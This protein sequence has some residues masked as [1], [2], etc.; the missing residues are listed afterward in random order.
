[1]STTPSINQE[2]I[3]KP[4]GLKKRYVYTIGG[5]HLLNDLM[6][7]GIIPVLLPLYKQAFNLT[8]T[9][10]GLIV[11]ISYLTSSVMQPLFGY[12]TDKKPKPWALAFGVFIT[13]LG[14]GLTGYASNY[15]MLLLFVAISGLGSG[16]FHPES[17]RGVYLASYSERGKAQAIYQVGGNLGQ[18]LGALILPLFILSVGL[19]GMWVFLLLAVVSVFLTIWMLPWYK[20]QLQT[21]VKLKKKLSGQN[22]YFGIS[23]LLIAVILR[24][25]V[26]IGVAG[27]LPFYLHEKGMALEKADLFTFL[28]LGAGAL[29]TYIGGR[30]S[31]RIRRKGIL[32]WS[33]VLS[34]PFS[35]LIPYAEGIWS[36][37]VIFLL[38]F[39][40]LSSFAVTVVYGQMLLPN[41]L[42][43]A[44]GLMI[45]FGVGAG[46]IGASF[47]GALSDSYGVGFVMHL[48][49]YF[50]LLAIV[51]TLLVPDDRKLGN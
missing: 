39:T 20:E 23:M 47:M 8:Y 28:F 22:N 46:G 42:S 30:M 14:L 13:G 11:L 49:T 45:G 15:Y 18:S 16:I 37:V 41:N 31:D 10:T 4:M 35:I 40:I 3:Q 12:L 44:S 50:I 48:F 43:M 27:F 51:F 5:A 6:T 33:L 34:I 24:S 9:Q 36:V 38:G 17:N 25:W 21:S 1:M 32:V 29:S 26:Q 7:V 2:V 19:H